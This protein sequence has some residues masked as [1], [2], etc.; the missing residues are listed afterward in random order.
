MD[1]SHIAVS[2]WT[3]CFSH[4]TFSMDQTFSKH[5]VIPAQTVS[6]RIQKKLGSDC[7]WGEQSDGEPR[8]QGNFSLSIFCIFFCCTILSIT[9]LKKKRNKQKTSLKKWKKTQ[10]TSRWGLLDVCSIGRVPWTLGQQN[11]VWLSENSINLPAQVT[12]RALELSIS[13]LSVGWKQIFRSSY[14]KFKSLEPS[15]IARDP[16]KWMNICR[17]GEKVSRKRLN[18]VIAGNTPIS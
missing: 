1:H 16:L 7:F 6:E 17:F 18:S 10:T 9:S 11:S 15:Q 13:W 2:I 5:P 12:L 14:L 3:T 8:W 4:V